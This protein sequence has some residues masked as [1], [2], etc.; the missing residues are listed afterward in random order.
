MLRLKMQTNGS[1]LHADPAGV[2]YMHI[3]NPMIRSGSELTPALL[4]AEIAKSYKMRGYLLDNPEVVIGMD[5]DI[6]SSSAIVPA[7]LK[8]MAHLRK[9]RKCCHPMI[10]R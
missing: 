7:S 10:C 9:R 2:L 1:G 8:R 3:H 6:G 5:A 4:E